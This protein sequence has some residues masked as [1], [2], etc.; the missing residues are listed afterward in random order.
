MYYTTTYDSI[1]I[2]VKQGKTP[3]GGMVKLI[4]FTYMQ[5]I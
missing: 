1:D 5:T 3:H 2:G 4:S